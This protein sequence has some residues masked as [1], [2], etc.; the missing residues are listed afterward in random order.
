MYRQMQRVTAL[1]G[2]LWY[3]CTSTCRLCS[4]CACTVLILCLIG[5]GESQT[6]RNPPAS[7]LFCYQC[8][9]QPDNTN[10]SRPVDLK[11]CTRPGTNVCTTKVTH[12]AERGMRI[13]KECSFGPCSLDNAGSLALAV[14]RLCD[15]RNADWECSK[16][17][18]TS[19]CNHNAAPARPHSTRVLRI[20]LF[21]LAVGAS[22]WPGVPFAGDP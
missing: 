6:S 18:G 11:P 21:L 14:D 5:S 17:C 8:S 13:T 20:L 4:L 10:C 1:I 15:R 22:H 9:D 2:D 12:N 7:E 3:R 19:G 16:C